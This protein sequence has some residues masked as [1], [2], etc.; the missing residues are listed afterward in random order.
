M[1]QLSETVPS[2]Q[3]KERTVLQSSQ[4]KSERNGWN[5]YERDKDGNIIMPR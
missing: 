4:R 1:K 5:I 2:L 3:V